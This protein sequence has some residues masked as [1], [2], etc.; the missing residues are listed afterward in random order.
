MNDK[1]GFEDWC[2]GKFSKNTVIDTMRKI[3]RLDKEMNLED[4]D[5]IMSALREKRRNG[6]T[7]ERINEHIKY[8]NRWIEF[9]EMEK[10]PYM[11]APRRKFTVRYFDETQARTLI[12]KSMG[13]NTEDLRDHTMILLALNTGLRRSEICNLRGE[14]LH[15]GYVRVILGKGEKTR[16]VYL[17]MDT[18]NAI[19]RYLSRRNQNDSPYV[20]TT[21]R[22][23]ISPEY[24]GKI[25]SRIRKRTGIDFSWHK[26]RHTYAKTL[27]RNDID[28]ETIRQMLG[29]EDLG[30]TQ[31][32][33]VID[34]GEAIER[35]KKGNVKLFEE[36]KRF[37][38]SKP[39][40]KSNGLEG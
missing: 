15:D 11:K 24:M 4:R 25:A 31:V 33:A 2:W 35:I 8:L 34:S 40:Y 39:W 3:K 36:T 29:H 26:C 28:L 23:R 5:E 18:R 32:Y 21:S 20:F 37:K 30:T 19:S 17:D 9:K 16:D 22:G 7:K 14:D 1:I 10:I 12:D 6:D 13:P 38:S 27:L